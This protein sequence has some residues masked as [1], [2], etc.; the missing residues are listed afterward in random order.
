MLKVS[1]GAAARS[2]LS[3]CSLVI[4][5]DMYKAPLAARVTIPRLAPWVLA[6]R[7]LG[8]PARSF[9]GPFHGP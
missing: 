4:G 1:F 6:A 7:G 8:P 2:V 3:A 5:Y 9:E